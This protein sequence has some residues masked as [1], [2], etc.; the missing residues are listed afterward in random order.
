MSVT[1]YVALPFIKTEDGVAPG[2]GARNA[3]RRRS[4]PA[5]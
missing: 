5:S 4:D 2:R 3:Q 1:Y